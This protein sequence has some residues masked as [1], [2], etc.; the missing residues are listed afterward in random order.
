[1]THLERFLATIERRPVDRPA[2]WLGMPTAE[3]LPAL[4]SHF[5]ARNRQALSE[6]LGDDIWPV[7]M[8]YHSPDA[9]AIYAALDFAGHGPESNGE[10]TLT[11][12]GFFADKT[13]LSAVDAFPW[14]DPSEH[15]SPSACQQAV[16]AAPADTAVMGM[17][18]S[19]HFQDACAA[20]GMEQALMTMVDAPDLFQTVIDRIT[21]FYLAANEIFYDAAGDC[22]HAVLIGNDF[23]SQ[24]GLMVSPGLLRKHV[25]SGTRRLIEQAHRYD[26]KVIH[27]S[28]GSIRD[29][30]PDLIELGADAIHPIQS[31]ASGMEPAGLQRD[32]GDQVA[33]CGGVDVQNLMVRGEPED[34]RGAVHE[35]CHL[36]PTGLIVSPSHEAL[37]PDVPAAN[38]EAMYMAVRETSRQG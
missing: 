24:L 21:D 1:M 4:L 31:L 5:G 6:Q 37:L 15:I 14:P 20:F 35:L 36:F 8:P 22:L 11:A 23:G 34:I 38:V 29:I 30:L 16:A 33:F 12:P 25:F 9:D 27:H 17:A 26:L 32:F 28:C 13:D 7:D 3:A 10:R 19:A 18:W 2:I